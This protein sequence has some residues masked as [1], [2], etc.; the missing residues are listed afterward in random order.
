[1]SETGTINALDSIASRPDTQTVQYLPLP[2]TYATALAKV[3]SRKAVGRTYNSTQPSRSTIEPAV[4]AVRKIMV[5][6]SELSVSARIS[7]TRPSYP[8][9]PSAI[10]II[11][12]IVSRE[13]IPRL[14]R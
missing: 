4:T 6:E 8:N 1:M 11:Q 7:R 10:R 9:T 2:R 12:K 5:R 14:P 3:H 13:S